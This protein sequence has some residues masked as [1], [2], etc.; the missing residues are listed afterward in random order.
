MCDH[1]RK[2]DI[3]RPIAAAVD[4]TPDKCTIYDDCDIVGI[5]YNLDIYETVHE[6]YPQKRVFASECCATGTTRDWHYP[7]DTNQRLRDKDADT[8]KSFLGR[9]KTYKILRSRE[10]VF[11]CFQWAAVEHRGEAEWPA[12]CSRSGALDLFLQKK[13][14]FYQN[15]SHW[16]QAPMAH[17]VP[18]WNFRGME[19]QKILV[20][21]YTN[22]QELE[23]MCN[24]ISYGRKEI[25]QYGHGEWEVPYTPGK[26]EV[27]GYRDGIL[28]AE[29]C[30]Q[31]TGRPE[32]LRITRDNDFAA[33]GADV[34]LFTCECL[35]AD[36]N[37][38]PDASEYV[39]FSAAAP[40]RILGTGSDHCDHNRVTN[41]DR[42]M[43]MGKIRVAV[44][45]E[46]GQKELVLTAWSDN[47]GSTSIMVL[48]EEIM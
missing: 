15:Q 38:V 27:K 44:K 33:N 11:G 29:D 13:G 21:V 5:N 34:A 32:R 22:C 4:K 43:Y 46:K 41:T 28:A 20:T 47:C 10:Y 7:T 26:L 40:A 16:T 25:E 37:P 17:I 6:Q 45:P 3:Y 24:G 39:R 48:P 18:H 31:T 2:L 14:A 9:E 35:D 12:I 36:G 8:T 19:G 42:K 30:R 23:L 1:I